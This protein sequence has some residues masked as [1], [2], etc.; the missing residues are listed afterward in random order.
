MSIRIRRVTRYD[1]PASQ[2]APL[3]PSPT[4]TNRSS[5]A[6]FSALRLFVPSLKPNRLRGV[7][8][9]V[10]VDD[11][12]PKP[13]CDQRTLTTP[14]AEPD[15]VADGVHGDLRVVGAG[16][17]AQVAA[18]D[19]GV[20]LVAGER[21]QLD[22]RRGTAGGQAEAVGAVGGREQ[23]GTEPD[24]Q[25][26]PGRGQPDRL[27]GVVRRGVLLAVHGADRAGVLPGG[28]PPGGRGPGLQ[29][30]DQVLA[31]VGGDVEGDEV[32]PV[33]RRGDDPGLVAAGERDGVVGPGPGR[34]RP[35][36]PRGR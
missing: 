10:L 2:S 35:A 26:E 21:R 23:R 28:H 7:A 15:Q 24:G 29:H 3:S 13:S 25:R 6:S 14:G 11:V 1:P 31:A 17:D 16:L 34:P 9:P 8:W 33:L 12:R 5:A 20:E 36:R 18:A 4:Q 30:L 22:Q 19:R 27:A 32:Q